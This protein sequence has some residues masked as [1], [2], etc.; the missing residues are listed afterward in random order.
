MAECH[1]HKTTRRAPK[2]W[3]APKWWKTQKLGK[4]SF[5]SPKSFFSLATHALKAISAHLVF[6]NQANSPRL[7][8]E[9]S[10]RTSSALVLNCADPMALGSRFG[11]KSLLAPRHPPPR[12]QPWHPTVVNNNSTSFKPSQARRQATSICKDLS[13]T[14]WSHMV[15]LLQQ[16]HLIPEILERKR[17]RT[18]NLTGSEAQ[19]LQN[20]KP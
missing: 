20:P 7:N 19:N 3:L 1:R 18:T 2:E 15:W 10:P 5:W 16:I 6:W 12:P 11:S 9:G 17:S 13:K 4:N 14:V 8:Y